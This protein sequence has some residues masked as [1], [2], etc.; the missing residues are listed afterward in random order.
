M[1]FIF[2]ITTHGFEKAGAVEKYLKDMGIP[3][4]TKIAPN[5]SN[6]SGRKKKVF[7]TPL[8]LGTVLSTIEKQPDWNNDAIAR[9]TGVSR[10]TVERI[11]AGKHALQTKGNVVSMKK[12]KS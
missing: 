11:R 8:I 4:E 6:H 9:E 2:T 1:N 7:V 5:R 10:A 12:D 3:F